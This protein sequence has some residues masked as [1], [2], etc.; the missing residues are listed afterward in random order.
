VKSFSLKVFSPSGVFIF[1]REAPEILSFFTNQEKQ[2]N[3]RKIK[4][5]KS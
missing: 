2:I 4:H 3:L 1:C 5:I